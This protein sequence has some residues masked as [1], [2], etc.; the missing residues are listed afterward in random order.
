MPQ[1]VA[2]RQ[3]NVLTV[4]IW[5]AVVQY[6]HAQALHIGMEHIVIRQTLIWIF[7]KLK[8]VVILQSF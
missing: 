3:T 6:A 7:V 1:L 2:K 4:Q 8:L 5:Y